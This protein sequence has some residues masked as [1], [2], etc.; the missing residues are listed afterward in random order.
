[1]LFAAQVQ[2]KVRLMLRKDG[3]LAA[4]RCGDAKAVIAKGSYLERSI[5]IKVVFNFYGSGTYKFRLS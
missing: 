2:D 3:V 1:M 4:I 5:G